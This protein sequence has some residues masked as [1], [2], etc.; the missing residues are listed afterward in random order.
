MLVASMFSTV[1]ASNIPGSIYLGPNP[2]APRPAP[3]PPEPDGAAAE[4]ELRFKAPVFVG[5]RVQAT[6]TVKDLRAVRS[7]ARIAVCETV[8]T[9]VQGLEASAA[10]LATEAGRLTVEGQAKVLCPMVVSAE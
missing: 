7:G 3:C 5:E 6:V 10:G 8:C 1:F 9:V 4:Q 2:L